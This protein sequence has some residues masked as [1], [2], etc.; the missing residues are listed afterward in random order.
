VAVVAIIV[1]MC[2]WVV[3]VFLVILLVMVIAVD[4]VVLA[5]ILHLSKNW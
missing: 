3:M 1:F 2:N 4:K 5:M